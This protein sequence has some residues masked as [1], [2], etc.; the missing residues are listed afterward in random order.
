MGA[1]IRCIRDEHSGA[2]GAEWGSGVLAE[3][4][5]VVTAMVTGEKSSFTIPER[6]EEEKGPGQVKVTE[7]RRQISYG[8]AL[9]LRPYSGWIEEQLA[10]GP[11]P[12]NGTEGS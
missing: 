5:Y 4:P 12:S 9:M 1:S 3:R 8:V 6:I 7:V 11:A 10:A 2:G